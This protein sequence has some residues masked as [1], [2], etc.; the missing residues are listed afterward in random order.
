MITNNDFNHIN[1]LSLLFNAII[2]KGLLS[3]GDINIRDP[4]SR[5]QKY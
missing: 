5:P 1:Y 2:I 3:L 4:E